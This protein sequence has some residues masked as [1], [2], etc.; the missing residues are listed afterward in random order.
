M[1]K[2]IILGLLILEILIGWPLS[3]IKNPNKISFK[4]IF[5]PITQEEKFH[6]DTKIGLDPSPVKKFY[7]NRTTVYKD[8]YLKNLLLLADPNNYFFIMHPRAGI[9]DI[10]N[11]FK[12]PF[13]AIIF[14]VVAIR[15]SA[16]DKKYHKIW[17]IILGEIIFLSFFKKI[18]GLDF[19]LFFPISYLLFL[20][21]KM[22]NKIK[23]G[24]LLNLILIG[25]ML[26]EMGRMYL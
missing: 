11:R 9:P 25:L 17:L 12:Y 8:R 22:I 6:L 21:A 13:W 19:I 4:T 20:G 10:V 18:D 1:F 3:L 15:L 5:F 26:I 14:L 16:R 7:Y 23:Y 24:W 2:K